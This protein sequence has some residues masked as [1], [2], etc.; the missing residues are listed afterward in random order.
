MKSVTNK[1]I[2]EYFLFGTELCMTEHQ[3]FPTK[4][5]LLA[6]LYIFQIEK[7]KKVQIKQKTSGGIKYQESF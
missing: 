2:L 7:K 4:C 5:C 6:T 1:F 3:S